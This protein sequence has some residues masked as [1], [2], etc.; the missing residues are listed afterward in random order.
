MKNLLQSSALFLI[1]IF[2]SFPV[3][4]QEIRYHGPGEIEG[5]FPIGWSKDGKIF[6]C[7][8]FETT[9]MISNGSQIQIR[10]QSLVTDKVLF[11]WVKS[12]DEG[13]SGPPDDGYY[14]TSAIEAWDKVVQEIE[15]DL[16]EHGIEEYPNKVENFPVQ[17]D[18]NI[19]VEI[20]VSKMD[21]GYSVVAISD[22]LGEKIITSSLESKGESFSVAGAVW[23]PAMTRLAVIMNERDW[24]HPYS[25]YWVVGCHATAGFK[26]VPTSLKLP[27]FEIMSFEVFLWGVTGTFNLNSD[28]TFSAF[29]EENVG[30]LDY[31][32]WE[33]DEISQEIVMTGSDGTFR[34]KMIDANHIQV[35]TD[36]VGETK[37][38]EVSYYA[39]K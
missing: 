10:I 7:G 33:Y 22:N 11:S 24:D 16:L 25:D 19:D 13:N 27:Y 15:D 4:P 20:R 18:N 12:W 8:W 34:W 2:I 14:P 9:Q 21:P 35:P 23:N 38:V 36:K 17:N 28:Y 29:G 32:N 1:S 31:G 30:E 3:I 6:A 39:P 26:P 37:V 5:F